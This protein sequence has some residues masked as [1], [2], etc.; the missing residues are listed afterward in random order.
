MDLA[1]PVRSNFIV[2][3][4]VV[5]SSWAAQY[6]APGFDLIA[7]D[8]FRLDGHFVERRGRTEVTLDRNG[9]KHHYLGSS[10]VAIC[11]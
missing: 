8:P 4:G 3:T 2:I 11:E 1:K 10:E 5:D 7:A 6:L 9:M